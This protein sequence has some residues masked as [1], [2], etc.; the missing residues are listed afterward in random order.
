MERRGRLFRAFSKLRRSLKEISNPA[1]HLRVLGYLTELR[2]NLSLTSANRFTYFL[3][4]QNLFKLMSI[5][6]GHPVCRWSLGSC[7]TTP[8]STP[9]T[10]WTSCDRS[11]PRTAASGTGWTFSTRTLRTTSWPA[12]GSP[13]L[14]SPMRSLPRP[15]LRAFCSGGVFFGIH[16]N[17]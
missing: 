16:G 5:S 4:S 15:R 11:T 13:P 1:N 6:H 9:R 3:R 8:A 14:S 7:A 17:T 2:Q 10:S 12:C